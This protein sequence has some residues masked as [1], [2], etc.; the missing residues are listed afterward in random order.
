MIEYIGVM[1]TMTLV[2][3]LLLFSGFALLF[4]QEDRIPQKTREPWIKEFTAGITYFLRSASLS[5]WEYF[6]VLS[7]LESG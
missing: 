6:W 2:S 5:G 7:N 1:P 4:I 3:T